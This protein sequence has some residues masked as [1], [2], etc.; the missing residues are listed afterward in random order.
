[1][2]KSSSKL[3]EPTLNQIVKGNNNSS[4]NQ[5]I[6][7]NI[8]KESTLSNNIE[9]PTKGC[10][11]DILF[12]S[13]EVARCYQCPL[14]F[15][16]VPIINVFSAIAGNAVI[17]KDGKFEN[18]PLHNIIVAA[19]SGSNK[20]QPMKYALKPL[21]DLNYSLYEDWKKEKK[22]WSNDLSEKKGEE[23][24][25]KQVIIS[26]STPEARNKAL[27]NNTTGIIEYSDEIATK[28]NNVG[29]YNNAKDLSPELSLWDGTDIII[30]RKG[31]DPMVIQ[32]PFC[33]VMGTIQPSII[34]S[35]FG[36]M[37]LVHSGYV[38]RC[39]WIY[40]DIYTFPDYNEH[41]LAEEITEDYNKSIKEFYEVIQHEKH[42]EVILSKEAKESYKKYYN[43]LQEKKRTANNDCTRAIYSKLSIQ[44]LRWGLSLHILEW[45]MKTV[46]NK[47]V[48]S[49]KTMDYAIACM[50]YFENTAFKVQ[51]LI[52]GDAPLVKL[53][54]TDVLKKLLEFY[55]DI[56][57]SQ[58]AKVL[59]LSQ[60]YISYL[61]K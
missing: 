52:N 17:L 58:L 49:S 40:P 33:S 46:E 56:N 14:E 36:A 13:K 11:E 59:K 42:L 25:L 7:V 12:Y 15:V 24:N 2:K 19:P 32:R 16:L 60:Q 4:N 1:M 26:D 5:Y 47:F 48:L 30:N 43:T 31:E 29:R 10:Q 50:K 3:I 6:E 37:N 57:Q 18:A 27:C 28:M 20:S 39:L 38:Q 22:T 61:C 44:C 35:V 21:L 53:T 8:P 55:P 41:E 51:A 45:A 9:F 34:K 23:P 54:K